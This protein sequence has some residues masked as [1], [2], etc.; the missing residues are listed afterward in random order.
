ME[1]EKVWDTI[2]MPWEKFRNRPVEEVVNF[3]NGKIGKILDLGCGSGRNFIKNKNSKFYGIDFSEKM[4]NLAREYAKKEQMDV[5]LVKSEVDKIPFD[6]NFFDAVIYSAVL[7]C[8]DSSDK[9]KKSLEEIY[10]VLKPGTE[11]LISVWSQNQKRIKNKPKETFVPW[12]VGEEKFLRYTYI[13]DKDELEQEIK[14]AGFEIVKI[15]EDKNINVI[16]RKSDND[17]IKE[18]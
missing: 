7:H 2:G 16:V 6:D 13:Y 11:A 10:R 5:E 12:T 4:L 3:L 8:V 9:R 1:Q 15:W 18:C 17:F 14:K